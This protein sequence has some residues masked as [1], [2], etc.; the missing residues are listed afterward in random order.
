MLFYVFF[1]SKGTTYGEE[2][3]RAM[4]NQHENRKSGCIIAYH[5]Y[6]GNNN[7][8]RQEILYGVV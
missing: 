3:E 8:E 2:T 1:G 5:I 7:N 6:V 4:A